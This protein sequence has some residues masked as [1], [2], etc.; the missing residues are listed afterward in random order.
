LASAVVN[1]SALEHGCGRKTN[2]H[3]RQ[4]GSSFQDLILA[5]LRSLELRGFVVSFLGSDGQVRWR[6]TEKELTQ[7]VS[8]IDHE[9]LLS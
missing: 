1:T 6:I 2:M 5:R 3:K 9:P 7:E 4:Q 8:E